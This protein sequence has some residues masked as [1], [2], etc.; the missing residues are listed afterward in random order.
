M[1]RRLLFLLACLLAQPAGA[2]ITHFSTDVEVAIDRGL[3]WLDD[4]GFYEGICGPLV[5]G[6]QEWGRGHDPGGLVALALLEKRRDAS[7]NA[8]SSGYAHSTVENQARIDSLMGLLIDRIDASAADDFRA[9]QDGGDLMALSVYYMTGGPNPGALMAVNK[10]FDRIAVNQGP[11][12]YW[13]YSSGAEADS[14][15]TQLVVAGLAAARRVFTST[16]GYA[17]DPNRLATLDGLAAIARQSYVDNGTSDLPDA[18]EERGHPYVR[19]RDANSLQQT[20]SGLWIQ[21]VG[22]AD[23]NGPS[24]QGYLRWLQ[25]RYQYTTMNFDAG[26]NA[27]YYYYY[28]WSFAKAM[29]FLEGAPIDPAA[30]NLSPVSMGRLPAGDAPAIMSRQT[31]LDP[32][33]MPRPASFGNDG[34]GYYAD[35][36]E[37]PRWYFDLAY[38]LLTQQDAAGRFVTIG[39]IPP[40][41]AG[42]PHRPQFCA[43]QAFAILV[44]QRSLGGGCIDTDGDNVCDDEDNCVL[45]PNPDQADVDGNG[46][47]DICE[48]TEICCEICDVAVLTSVEQCARAGGVRVADAACCPEVCCQMPDGTIELTHAEECI[49]VGGIFVELELCDAPPPAPEVCC[50][51]GPDDLQLMPLVLCEGL[52]G[53]WG[54]AAECRDVCCVGEAGAQIQPSA[55]CEGEALPANECV[56]EVCCLV[57]GELGLALLEQCTNMGQVQPSLA[58]CADTLCC[59][60]DDGPR[61]LN[62]AECLAAEGVEAPADACEAVCCQ[63]GPEGDFALVPP[64]VCQADGG[65]EQPADACVDVCCLGED[66]V[67]ATTI[68]AGACP[69]EQLPEEQCESVC[70]V[71]EQEEP[72]E[73]SRFQCDETGRVAPVE[74]CDESICCLLRDGT[75]ESLQPAFC[76]EQAG[77]EHPADACIEI[78]CTLLNG[79]E[80]LATI[81]CSMRDGVPTEPEACVPDICC[82]VGDE[83]SVTNAEECAAQGGREAPMNWCAPD[84]CCLL[85]DGTTENMRPNECAERGLETDMDQCAEVCCRRADREVPERTTAGTCKAWMGMEVDDDACVEDPVVCCKYDD[86]TARLQDLSACLESGGAEAD[87][88]VCQE[89]QDRDSAPPAPPADAGPPDDSIDA[90]EP[91]TDATSMADGGLPS[92]PTSEPDT[93][94]SQSPDGGMPVWCLALFPLA[95]ARRRRRG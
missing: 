42:G 52:E 82:A 76:A 41:P 67:A 79:P 85:R 59:A 39:A 8:V 1:L 57:E 68:P 56:A 49:P 50:S 35:P 16:P 55:L 65:A 26:E 30:G 44:L 13:G 5:P 83:R 4:E 6:S 12:G 69:G 84:V 27:R 46:V 54:D 25:L 14:S 72:G 93:G 89:Q 15:T 3:Q 43:D 51:L 70:C 45:T 58:W 11:H 78:C 94:C 74:W 9:Y 63:S 73:T 2:Q 64:H 17:G 24:V 66:Q 90:G 48:D 88:R 7:Q 86:G 34:P 38:T 33:L 19:G 81:Q 31:N 32:A 80:T 92:D 23:L 61:V 77:I 20:A 10:I 91:E 47:G 36:H 60:L 21:L 53:Q 87:L 28:F 75:V 40:N 22:G 29:G 95:L 71:V 37:Q 18:P 62:P